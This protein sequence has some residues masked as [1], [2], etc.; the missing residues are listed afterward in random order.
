MGDP[1]S[2]IVEIEGP[3]WKLG[4][5]P[6]VGGALVYASAR[7]GGDWLCVTRPVDAAIIAER[8]VRKLG[9]FVLAPFCNRIE[10]ATFNYGGRVYR[11]PPNW[12]F[13]PGT[14]IHGASWQRPWTIRERTTGRLTLEQRVDEAEYSFSYDAA[15][16]FDVGGPTAR[17][18]LAITNTGGEE[19]PFGAGFHPYLRR[20]PSARLTF[21]ADGWL[22]PDAR[23]FPRSWRRTTPERSAAAGRP[24][25]DFAGVD[26]TFT[27]WSRTALLTWPE[28]GVSLSVA[29]S[30]S[31]R[32]LHVFVPEGQPFLCLEPVSHVVDVI[33]RR[34]FARYGDMIPLAP[35]KQLSISMEWRSAALG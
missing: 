3:G 14:A 4:I 25:E 1:A 9:G 21:A 30:D 2:E 29:A 32:G 34:Q 16:T 22:E 31:A 33:N 35:R 6:E 12:P 10:G 15:L 20:T 5:W 26:A 28:L 13:D 11:L 7:H 19:L 23:C 24:V 8:D 17:V 18:I 27:G